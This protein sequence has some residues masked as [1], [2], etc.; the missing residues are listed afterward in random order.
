MNDGKPAYYPVLLY[1]LLLLLV[2]GGSWLIELV[3]LFAGESLDVNSLVSGEGV[4]WALL[5][6]EASLEAAPWGAAFFLLFVVG[7]LHGSGLL[8]LTGNMLRG[9]ASSKELRSLLFALLSL[10]LYATVL[11][12]FTV[13]P[14]NA[15]CSVTGSVYNSPFSHGWMLVLFAGVLMMSLV[16]GFV[17]GNYR[18]VVDVVG[19]AA[20]FV[21]MFVPALLAMLPASGIMPCL[22]YTG[23]DVVAGV[24]CGVAVA[25]E[26][27]LYCLPFVYVAILCLVRK[28]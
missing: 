21:R 7:L 6:A 28:R 8:R 5:N 12:L 10:M 13:S 24:E 25:V 14:W 27:L 23:L 17:Y 3:L 26:V 4:R 15:L 2:W 1:S 16:Y 22:R 20:G 18:T 9:R 19:T 11:F